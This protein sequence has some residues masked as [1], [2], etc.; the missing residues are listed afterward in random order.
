LFL[1][2]SRLSARPPL[3][4]FVVRRQ[5]RGYDV[6]IKTR[7]EDAE[8]LWSDG[9]KEGAWVPALIAAAATARR[10]YPRPMS[11]N[12][13]FKRFICDIAVVIVSGNVD[14]PGPQSIRFYTDNRA[15]HRTLEDMFYAELRCNLV[16]E[17][18]L[19]EVGFSDSRIEGDQIVASLS[20]PTHGAAEI[21]DFWVL[22]LIAAVKAAPENRDMWPIAAEPLSWP[23]DLKKN[24]DSGSC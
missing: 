10:R 16:H 20:V 4:S 2:T 8:H 7:I 24:E 23:T 15:D 3:Q 11:D 6:S 14:A 21:P 22:H 5:R 12:Q 13:S 9:R 18:E 17:A 19:K 1:V